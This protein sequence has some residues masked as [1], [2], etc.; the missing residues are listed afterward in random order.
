MRTKPVG[1]V[2]GRL[3]RAVEPGVG[4]AAIAGFQEQLALVD[5]PSFKALALAGQEHS[6]ADVLETIDVP[7]LVVQGGLDIMAPPSIGPE[8]V[9]RVR[10]AW[11]VL[12]ERAGHTGLLGHAEEIA[13]LVEGFLEEHGLL[14]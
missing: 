11:H 1:Y 3:V 12:L 8:I 2:A 10:Q 9:A 14:G 7:M 6:A 13:D 4:Y 5:G